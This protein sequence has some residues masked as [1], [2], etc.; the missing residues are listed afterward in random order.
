MKQHC[1]VETA[2]EEG[3]RILQSGR[4][5]PVPLIYGSDVHHYAGDVY[6]ISGEVLKAACVVVKGSYATLYLSPKIDNRRG[7]R[8]FELVFGR[9][10]PVGYH[11][12][13]LHP[14][15]LTKKSQLV[16]IGCISGRNNSSHGN[17]GG[18]PQFAV[19]A[20]D[21]S[22][23]ELPQFH[24]MGGPTARQLG[25]MVQNGY[26]VPVSEVNFRSLRKI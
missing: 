1:G 5:G 14:R 8:L 24:L 15:S 6:Q 9:P 2:A 20:M 11:L 23:S 21:L 10:I 19:K 16:A 18:L 25:R 26:L 7:R 22:A 13:H 12:E 4:R 17:R 3:R